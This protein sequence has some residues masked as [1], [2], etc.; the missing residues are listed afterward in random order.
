MKEFFDRTYYSMFDVVGVCG[1]NNYE[2]IP[3]LVGVWVPSCHV[4]SSIILV[5]SFTLI[6]TLTL[7]P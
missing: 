3:L 7:D 1:A 5:L 4:F 6:L 2:E